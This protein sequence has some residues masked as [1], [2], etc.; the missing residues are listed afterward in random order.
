MDYYHRWKARVV[1]ELRRDARTWVARPCDDTAQLRPVRRRSAAT[2]YDAH[3]LGEEEDEE[4]SAGARITF[5]I[6]P[7]TTTTTIAATMLM[8]SHSSFAIWAN[9]AVLVAILLLEYARKK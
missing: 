4:A 8:R 2:E 6:N 7:S 9:A 3:F 1:S 5:A